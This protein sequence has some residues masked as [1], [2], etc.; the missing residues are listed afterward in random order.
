MTELQINGINY[1]IGK[2]DAMRQ[3]HL[4]R[5]IA[6]IIPTLIPIFLTI[7]KNGSITKDLGGLSELLVPFTNSLSNLSDESS[8]YVIATC[9]SVVQRNTTTNNWA[10]VWSAQAKA[11][12]FDDMGLNDIIKL[13]VE[14]IKDN[15]GSFIPGLLTNLQA[16]TTTA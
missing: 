2:L 1:R 11:C 16:S 4:S 8:E 12:M 3:F 7:A 6:P 14:V 10:N 13:V 15:L 9:L 5:R